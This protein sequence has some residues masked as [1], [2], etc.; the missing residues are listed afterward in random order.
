[1]AIT[2]K[3]KSLLN[4]PKGRQAMERGRQELSKPQNQQK[5]RNLLNRGNKKR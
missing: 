3:I 4:S 2:D 1:M 5:L